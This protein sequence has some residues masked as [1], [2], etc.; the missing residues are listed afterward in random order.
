MLA[1][2]PY[3]LPLNDSTVSYFSGVHNETELFTIPRCSHA[4]TTLIK[5][6]NSNTRHRFF[7]F[8]VQRFAFKYESSKISKSYELSFLL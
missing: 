5:Q 1:T 7:T 8:L 2:N 4:R 6:S 3:K